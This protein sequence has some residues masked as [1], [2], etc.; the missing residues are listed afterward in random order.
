MKLIS[1][2]KYT[3][4]RESGENPILVDTRMSMFAREGRLEDSITVTMQDVIREGE[5][6]AHLAPDPVKAAAAFASLG[7]D[8]SHPVVLAGDYTDPAMLRIAWTLEYA[9]HSNVYCISESIALLRKNGLKMS[10]TTKDASVAKFEANPNKSILVDAKSIQ[11]SD[12]AYVIDA[13]SMPEY[14]AGHLPGAVLIPHTR[15]LGDTG[16]HFMDSENL[17]KTFSDV[18]RDKE[19]FCYCMHGTRASSL[20]YQL[21]LAGFE[22]VHLYDGSFVQWKG[23]GLPLE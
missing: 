14:T 3:Q 17:K 11:S 12:S 13:R 9:G 8:S 4:M 10:E 19:I 2:A 6:G 1:Y 22:K 7:I 18:P 21:R 5:F 16:V 20:F 23:L 15:G